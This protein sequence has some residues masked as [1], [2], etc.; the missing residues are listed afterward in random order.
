MKAF[1]RLLMSVLFVTAPLPS[2]SLA[3]T[4]V[5]VTDTEAAEYIGH[6]VTVEGVVTAVSTSRKGN[7]FINCGGA[8]PNQ[9][10]TGW[11]PAGNPLARDPWITSLKGKTIKIQGVIELYKGKP[12]IRIL[13]RD[14][15]ITEG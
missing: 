9:T 11:V 14:Q 4:P 3:Q 10:F 13:S 7:T 1:I 5:V 2:P 8:Y 15:I 6:D 12:E